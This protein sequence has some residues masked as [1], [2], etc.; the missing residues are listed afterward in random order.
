M[1]DDTAKREIE[2]PNSMA[3]I[4]PMEIIAIARRLGLPLRS[5]ALL[6]VVNVLSIC[7]E[8]A[9]I[10]VLL[11]VFELLRSG[12]VDA[13]AKMQGK[14]WEL[15]REFSGY[16]GIPI[17]LGLLLSASFGFILLRQL[18]RYYAAR[19][20]GM[21][22]RSMANNLRQRV[23]SRFLV[24]ETALQ[25][26]AQVGTLVPLLQGE[27]R[28][29]LDVF[30]ALTQSIS[31]VFQILAYFGALFLVSPIMSILCVGVMVLASLFAQGSLGEI[32]RRGAAMTDMNKRI[33]A[34]MVERLQHARLIRLSNTEKSETK[35]FDRL[36]RRLADASL[37]QQLINTRMQL[38]LEPAAVGI[39]YLTVFVGGQIFGIGIDRVGLFAIVLI[40]LVPSLRNILT[41]YSRIV[42]QMP[43]LEW[44]DSYMKEIVQARE[45]KG[46]ALLLERLDDGIRFDHVSF[47]YST[48]DTPALWD[49][50]FDIAAHR[51]TALVGPSGA[52]KSTVID[53]LP[54]L[55]D[56][57]AG[58]IRLDG[59]PI[60]EYST[61]SLRA[62]I[63]FVP[64]Q[65]QIFDISVA[66][67]IR[68]GK[69]DAT[70]AEV[71]EAARLAGALDFIER[72]PKGFDTV[73]GDDGRRL[74]G[75]QR[76]RLD[77]ARALV[78]RAPVLILDEPTSALDAEAESAFREALRTLRA[79]TSLTIIVIAH[80]LSTIADA[81]QIIVMDQGHVTAVGTHEVL[82]AGGGWYADAYRMQHGVSRGIRP[83][84]RQTTAV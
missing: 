55:R 16:V 57:S 79:E 7:F 45:P 48:S 40:R 70:D 81:D 78:R 72:L 17:S 38:I 18:F 20:N 47:S 80:R 69:E 73:L 8:V 49:V 59:V 43:S 77:I 76:Q 46:G 44:L 13:I 4:K 53:L 26:Q 56:P 84:F 1:F 37:Q 11:P 24:A 62:G 65:P 15:M 71:R 75:G 64:Q 29:G 50:T 52:G 25:D 51:M 5:F 3:L 63:A 83:Q 30:L 36:S 23:F 41:Q 22:E 42:G 67:H 35:A 61:A 6:L 2:R 82:M 21:V 68:Y 14:H 66:E 19:Y 9:A 54:R 32:K 74:S 12:K 28:R 33:A 39:G 58:T 10:A 31:V 34:F 27:L 60:T